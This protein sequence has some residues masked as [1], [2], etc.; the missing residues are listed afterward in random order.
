MPKS[1]VIDLITDQE[2]AFARLV[3]SSTV[4]DR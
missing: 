2:M 4:T 3:L 1:E